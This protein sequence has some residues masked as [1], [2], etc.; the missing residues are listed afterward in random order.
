MKTRNELYSKEAAELLRVVSTYKSV[1]AEQLL[2]LF[3]GKEGKVRTILTQ[4]EKQGR[5]VSNA[6]VVTVPDNSD[7]PDREMI[8]SVWVLLDFI[9]RAEYHTAGEFPVKI[10]FFA[11]AEV[12]GIIY[13]APGKEALISR[14]MTGADPPRRLVIVEDVAQIE[15]IHIA[16]TAGYCAVSPGGEVCYYKQEG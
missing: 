3:P 6:G 14:A 12:F 1:T 8:A 2:R 7:A 9:E 10:C 15:R 5:I 16:N 13:A 11:D 4:L